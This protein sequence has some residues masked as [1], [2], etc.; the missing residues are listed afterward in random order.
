MDKN[1]EK[2]LPA[3]AGYYQSLVDTKKSENKRLKTTRDFLA[4]R[5]SKLYKLVSLLEKRKEKLEEYVSS[6]EHHLTKGGE[7]LDIINQKE[8]QEESELENK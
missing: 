1:E 5:I 6:L 3:M 4:D 2:I 8:E 7:L